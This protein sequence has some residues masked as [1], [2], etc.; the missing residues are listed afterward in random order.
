[1]SSGVGPGRI[2]RISIFSTSDQPFREGEITRRL[3]QPTVDIFSN[4]NIKGVASRSK[5]CVIYYIT[6][7]CR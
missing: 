2:F 5:P 1:M 4:Y 6:G 3:A 7:M